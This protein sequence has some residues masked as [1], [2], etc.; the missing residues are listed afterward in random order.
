MSRQGGSLT[1]VDRQGQICTSQ[2][3]EVESP[4]VVR[5]V[6]SVR[7]LRDYCGRDGGL[8]FGSE[9]VDALGAKLTVHMVQ[10]ESALSGGGRGRL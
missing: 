5:N 9:N 7:R 8:L 4:R 3:G 10:K 2:A 6:L 1:F